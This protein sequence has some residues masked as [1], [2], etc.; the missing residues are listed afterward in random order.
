[1]LFN[2]QIETHGDALVNY[3]GLLKQL[4]TE[5]KNDTSVYYECNLRSGLYLSRQCGDSSIRFGHDKI[6]LA[7]V[8]R[9]GIY[10]RLF[11]VSLIMDPL[12]GWLTDASA[13]VG[14]R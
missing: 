7:Q 3:N 11:H 12:Y 14:M 8:L 10:A 4:S 1:M 6:F 13:T 5:Q 2:S 9:V